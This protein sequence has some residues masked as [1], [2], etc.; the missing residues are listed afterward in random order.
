MGICVGGWKMASERHLLSNPW[1]CDS[2]LIWKKRTGLCRCDQVNDPE[3]GRLSCIIQV[4]SEWN[5]VHSYTWGGARMRFYTHSGR[6]GNRVEVEILALK[7]R[8]MWS[9]VKG[10]QGHQKLEKAKHGFSWEPLEGARPYCHLDFSLV[11][12]ILDFWAPE[13]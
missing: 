12:S 9:Q 2:D 8:G 11:I 13:L 1:T 4:G 5:H 3:M 6:C 7:I 10:W